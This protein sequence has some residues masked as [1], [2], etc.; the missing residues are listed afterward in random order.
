MKKIY[1]NLLIGFDLF[2]IFILIVN[3]GEIIV[4]S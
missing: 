1:V 4:N 2:Y 3:C